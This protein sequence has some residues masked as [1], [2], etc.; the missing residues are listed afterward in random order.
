MLTKSVNVYCDNIFLFM[1]EIIEKHFVGKVAQKAVIIKNESVLL[2]RDPR[3]ENEIWELPGGRLNVGESSREGLAR[4]IF[5]ELGIDVDV[6]EVIHIEQFHQ[7]SEG[8]NALMI[9]YRAI[10]KNPE[11]EL[12]PDCNE[13]AEV[14]FVPVSEAL[15]LNLFPEYRRAIEVYLKKP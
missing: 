10:L 5:E 8:K 4:E 11:A 7:G 2:V 6:H 3:E 15:T 12:K 1:K 13:I 9:A 14:R